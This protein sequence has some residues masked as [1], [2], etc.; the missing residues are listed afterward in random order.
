[1][2]FSEMK[3][4]LRILLRSKELIFWTLVFPFAL[5]TFMY[6]AFGSIY[7][8]TEKFEPVPTA[9]VQKGDNA[10][11]AVMLGRI[12]EKKEDGS[13]LSLYYTGEE[14]AQKM[15]DE[16][17]V[18]GILYIDKNVSLK[19]KDNGM[20]QTILQ[21]ILKQFI[22]YEKL[23]SDVEKK[24]PERI[25]KVAERIQNQ[26]EY[27]ADEKGNDADGDNLINYFYAIF[28]MVCLFASFAG[29]DISLHLQANM[30][31]LGQRRNVAG[32]GK[33]KML[34]ADFAASEIVQFILVCL[35]LLYMRFVLGL[36]VGNR[37]AAILM[38]LFVGT[39]FGIMFGMLIGA[40]P[41]PG[42]NGKMGILVSSSLLFCAMS[43]L[44]VSGVKDFIEHHIPILN[45]IN[46]AALITDAFYALN[47]YDTYARYAADFL[48]LTGL[49]LICGIVCFFIVRRNCHASL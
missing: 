45:D 13:L 42:E 21:M 3:Y 23:L 16:E 4:A 28:A 29:Y 11:F 1:M 49:T 14:Q 2:F 20:N 15:L 37:Y 31:A 5:A 32:M 27:F 19:I 39:A 8:T 22:Q 24:N 25:M 47:V 7:E 10:A 46:P 17:A 9:V 33:M 35:L 48:M 6:L 40:L 30:S 44:M 43:D 34:L 36:N 38:I 41:R 12:S 18:S 26:T